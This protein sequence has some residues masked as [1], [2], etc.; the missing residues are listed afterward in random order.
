MAALSG[1]ALGALATFSSAWFIQ[2][3]TTRRERENRIWER[4]AQVYDEVMILLRRMAVLREAVLRTGRF[5][6][7]RTGEPG[8]VDDVVPLLARLEIYASDPLL[9]AC[10][11]MF[12]A[13]KAWQWAWGAWRTQRDHH[14]RRSDD[15]DLWVEFE[16]RARES[17]EADDVV[18]RLLR[19]EMHAERRSGRWRRPVRGRPRP[20]VG[21]NR[22][23]RRD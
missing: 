23:V 19:A 22:P 20:R 3:A 13:R 6:K 16:A 14:P 12:A 18:L 1:T 9:D 7:R 2:R 10:E 11:D 17:S 8:P 15:D 5:P 4:R 21:R